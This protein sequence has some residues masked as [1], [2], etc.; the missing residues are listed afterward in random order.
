MTRIPLNVDYISL[1]KLF[2]TGTGTGTF[3]QAK[4][5]SL[6]ERQSG[7]N[8][9]ERTY[10]ILSQNWPKGIS[11]FPIWYNL[12]SIKCYI[13][14]KYQLVK[15]KNTYC[16]TLSGML[17]CSSGTTS[18]NSANVSTKFSLRLNLELHKQNKKRNISAKILLHM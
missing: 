10:C 14:L 3:D 13:R 6:Y 16:F 8:R 5:T 12:P 11:S 1:S 15:H 17:A 2:A 4:I 9:T 7:S 18:A